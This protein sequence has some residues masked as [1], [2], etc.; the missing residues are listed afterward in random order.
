MEPQKHRRDSP[1]HSRRNAPPRNIPK[2][3]K[4]ATIHEVH[5]QLEALF[6]ALVESGNMTKMPTPEQGDT[7]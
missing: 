2:L 6:D 4:N 7:A 3:S 1:E 5:S